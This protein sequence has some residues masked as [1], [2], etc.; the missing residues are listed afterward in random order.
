MAALSRFNLTHCV[1][2]NFAQLYAL[3]APLSIF[4]GGY[5]I[6]YFFSGIDICYN[7]GMH[8]ENTRGNRAHY[9]AKWRS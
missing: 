1:H 7:Y 5:T 2:I 9:F 8:T 6:S 4:D 3:H